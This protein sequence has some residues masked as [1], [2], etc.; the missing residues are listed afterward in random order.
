MLARMFPE[1]DVILL[2]GFKNSL[3]PK[4]VCCYSEEKADAGRF[5]YCRRIWSGFSP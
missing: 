1:A 3:Y 2:E 4:Y 5:W